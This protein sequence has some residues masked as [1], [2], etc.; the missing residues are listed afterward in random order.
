MEFWALVWTLVLALSLGGFAVL[1]VVVTIGGWKD[2]RELL[3][4]L[5]KRDS[6]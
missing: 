3:A 5:R 1:A 6:R 4:D 2:L